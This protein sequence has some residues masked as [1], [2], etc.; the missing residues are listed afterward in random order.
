MLRPPT[1]RLLAPLRQ[2]SAARASW[3]RSGRAALFLASDAATFMKG[4]DLLVDG[5]YTAI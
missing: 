3:M 5:G 4:S 1:D 2:C